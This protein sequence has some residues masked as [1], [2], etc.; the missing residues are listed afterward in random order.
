MR[1]HVGSSSP[2]RD[3][4]GPPA[5]G[6]WSPS[7]QT[8]SVV[9][10]AFSCPAAAAAKSLQLCPTLC[11]PIDAA[12]QAPPSLGFSRQEHWSGL[13][14]PSAVQESEKW[15]W[16]RSLE[17]HEIWNIV[18]R[19]GIPGTNAQGLDGRS[20]RS[21]VWRDQGGQKRSYSEGNLI[22]ICLV[23]V[24]TGACPGRLPRREHMSQGWSISSF[25]IYLNYYFEKL[26]NKI[27]GVWVHQLLRV[28][29]KLV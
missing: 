24:R 10:P 29:V 12:H 8:T 15:K 26:G 19:Y 1:T 22:P 23:I 27:H 21:I 17:S 28:R 5:L 11:D 13:P 7:H 25:T 9:L 3:Q 18:W 2:T 14:F 20:V 4:V 16:S 6:A